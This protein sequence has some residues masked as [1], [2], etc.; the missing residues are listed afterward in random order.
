MSKLFGRDTAMG[1]AVSLLVVVGVLVSEAPRSAM[2]A[3][4]GESTAYKWNVAEKGLPLLDLSRD[5]L[6]SDFAQSLT[7][8]VQG[9]CSA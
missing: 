6:Q 8:P 5:R 9:A 2:S 3:S 1:L 4:A 7:Y